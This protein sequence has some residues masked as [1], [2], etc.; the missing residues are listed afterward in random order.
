METLVAIFG[1]MAILNNV[2]LLMFFSL[3][4]FLIVKA[5]ND[6]DSPLDWVDLLVENGKMSI[7]RLGQFWGIAISSWVIIYMA[8]TPAA[9]TI[10]P[11]IFPAWLG[12]LLGAYGWAKYLDSKTSEKK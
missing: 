4:L 5:N 6:K 3:F 9:Y 12:F 10:F 1:S 2:L 7:S 8:Q 11:L